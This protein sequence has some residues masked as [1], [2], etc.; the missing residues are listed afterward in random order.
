MSLALPSAFGDFARALDRDT[1]KNRRM[2]ELVD[3]PELQRLL[4]ADV[5][6]GENQIER[7][8]EADLARE[9]LRPARAGNQSQLHFGQAEDCLRMIGG[10]AI[11]TRERRLES[12]AEAGAVDCGDDRNPEVLDG[13]EQHLTIATQSFR[14]GCCLEGEKLLDV[15]AGD[16]DVGLAADENRGLDGRVALEATDQR[17][18][19][20]LYRAIELVHRL[21]R[22]IER[23]D[24]D[25][26]RDF[27]RQRGLPSRSNEPADR[28]F[29]RRAHR[30]L[31][32]TIA[33]PIPPAAHTVINPN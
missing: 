13:V 33:N 22:Q 9:S 5:L 10:D 6:P 11:P 28:D 14:I 3:Q 18:E 26:V 7:V 4:R 17:H 25:A 16:P 19:L 8:G 12:S 23:D 27:D 31:S 24:R 20:V 30:V 32:T 15:G 21:V 2:N 29:R 1:S